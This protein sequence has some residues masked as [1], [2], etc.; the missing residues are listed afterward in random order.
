MAWLAYPSVLGL[1]AVN[2]VPLGFVLTGRWDAFSLLFA[3]WWEGLLLAFLILAKVNVVRSLAPRDV[4]TSFDV[5]DL[6]LVAYLILVI[7]FSLAD[8][9]FISALGQSYDGTL[10]SLGHVYQVGFGS[11]ISW[12]LPRV[13]RWSVLLFV[14][15]VAAGHG[16]SFWRNYLERQEYRRVHEVF[17]QGILRIVLPQ[18][19][20]WIF[21]LASLGAA[22]LSLS[23]AVVGK[24]VLDAGLHLVE[25]MGGNPDQRPQRFVP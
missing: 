4:R 23:L 14:L 21:A 11:V 18:L 20:A 6:P 13:F 24:T 17:G 2:L 3:Y 9:W 10:T 15:L 22:W 16:Y 5:Y 12:A 8:F 7:V 25:R 1:I 19:G